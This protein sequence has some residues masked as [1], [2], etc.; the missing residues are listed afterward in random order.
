M[1]PVPDSQIKWELKRERFRLE[2]PFPPPEKRREKPISEIL[3]GLLS[4][5]N[6]E[7][8]PLP[9]IIDQRWP[10]IAGEQLAKHVRPYRLQSGVLYL[11]ADHPGWLTEVKRL[12]REQWLKKIRSI[13]NAP[14]IKD[15]RVQL[16]PLLKSAGRYK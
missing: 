13:Q 5:N 14:D 15:V 16:D 11:Y 12:P 6:P 8:P 4:N 7:V 9:E 10:A 1:E 3:T 2:N